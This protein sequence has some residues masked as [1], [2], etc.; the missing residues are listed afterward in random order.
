M[1]KNDTSFTVIVSMLLLMFLF[2]PVISFASEEDILRRLE[3]ME[4]EI[5]QLKEENTQLR[6]KIEGSNK[7]DAAENNRLKIMVE[8]DRKELQELKKSAGSLASSDLSAVLGKYNMQIYGRVKV[9]LNYDTAEF[10]KYNDGI[11]AVGN[12]DAEND[13]SN[14]NPRDSRFGIKVARRDG[15]WHEKL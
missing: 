15:T 13:S 7:A 14:F 2:S 5:R 3:K 12:G 10:R 1:Q 4:Q 11:G 6:Q 9:D 8:H